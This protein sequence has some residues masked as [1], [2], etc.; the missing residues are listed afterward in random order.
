M[1][2]ASELFHAGQLQDAIAAQIAKVKSSPTDQPARFF[3]FEL[4]LFSGDLDR[5]RSPSAGGRRRRAVEPA[6]HQLAV[7]LRL[8]R[9][10]L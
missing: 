6:Q 9:G 7:P 2:N 5:A 10:V 4:F 3:L 1:T 8:G